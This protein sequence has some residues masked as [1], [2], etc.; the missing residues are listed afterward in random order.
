MAV[1][2]LVAAAIVVL[3]VWRPGAGVEL[4]ELSE[5]STAT[6]GF[7]GLFPAE[8][9]APLVN[10]LGIAWDGNV[11]YVAESDA[12]RIARLS[13]RGAD[14]GTIVLPGADD[15]RSSYPS[16]ICIGGEGRLAVV[17]N[18][19]SRVVLIG[20]EAT[21]AA[22]VLVTFGAKTVGHPTS[23][24][25]AEGEYYVFDADIAAVR[26]FDEDGDE[27][28]VLGAELQPAVM[29]AS[30]MTVL[31]GR[32][33]IADSNGGRVLAI[34]AES[35]KQELVFGN[36]YA[37]PRSI[38]PVGDDVLAVVDTFAAAAFFTDIDGARLEV[39]DAETVPEAPLGSVRSAVWLPD[40]ERLY[41]TDAGSGRV[42]VFNA[43][44]R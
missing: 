28:R 33:Y 10:P 5:E 34:D 6:V 37:L 31:D 8:D 19:G 40:A 7:A 30:G 2:V 43:R 14:L 3:Q 15:E 9:D 35:G 20:T 11:L 29:F 22:E 42:F 21:E 26:V 1:I 36:R 32:L 39:I 4:R 44:I 17:D 13:D 25:Y 23:V 16:A 27:V 38:S 41:L 12:G 24:T 18:A